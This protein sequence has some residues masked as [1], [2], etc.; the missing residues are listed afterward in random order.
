[1]GHEDVPPDAHHCAPGKRA[2]MPCEQAAQHRGFAPRPQGGPSPGL[3]TAARHARH[4]GSTAH[5]QIMHRVIQ[6]IYFSAQRLKGGIGSW[7]GGGLIVHAGPN[8]RCSNNAHMALRQAPL[9]SHAKV[10]PLVRGSVI[11]FP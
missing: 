1:M 5:E 3:G 9:M 6:R 10:A 11:V 8:L 4:N 2:G 7:G